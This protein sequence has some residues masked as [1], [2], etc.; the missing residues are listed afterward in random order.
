[1][2]ER[3][4]PDATTA[5]ALLSQAEDQ[6]AQVAL[7]LGEAARRAVEGEPGAAK[8]AAQ[9]AR[10]LRD[11]FRIL[12]SERERVDKLRTQIA[13]IA[14]AHELDFDAACEARFDGPFVN[15]HRAD[16][17][18]ILQA[19][20][21]PGTIRFGHRLAGLDETPAGIRLAYQDTEER[22]SATTAP[23]SEAMMAA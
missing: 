22:L 9:A 11:A 16:L 3:F 18:R 6:F 10:E 12:M 2:T 20:L 5:E 21:A 1:M 17:H 7:E 23:N 13:G 4:L 8:L 15:I 14:G 19:P